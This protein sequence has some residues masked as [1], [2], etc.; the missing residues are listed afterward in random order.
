MSRARLYAVLASL[1]ILV[2]VML[3]YI[4][5]VVG[6][7][8][9]PRVT[10][11]VIEYYPITTTAIKYYPTPTTVIEY[12][13]IPK[14]S[15][16]VG[17][18]PRG[19][20]SV[21]GDY[22]QLHSLLDRAASRYM[23]ESELGGWFER[24]PLLAVTT[25]PAMIRPVGAVTPS[26]P[27][28]QEANVRVSWTNVQVEGVDELDIVKTNGRIIA[29]V[30]NTFNDSSI[31]IVD[32]GSKSVASRIVLTGGEVAKGLF[33]LGDRLVVVSES[34]GRKGVLTFINTGT[35]VFAVYDGNVT[36]RVFDVS[37]PSKPTLLSLTRVSGSLVD[38][39]M[40]EGV[41]YLVANQ[42]SITQEGLPLIPLVDMRPVDPSRLIVLSEDARRYI[43]I[44]ALNITSLE[45]NVVTLAGGPST[46]IYMSPHRLYIAVDIK[47]GVVEAYTIALRILASVI[48]GDEGK[49]IVELVEAGVLKEALNKAI[50]VLSRKSP[51]ESSRIWG[52]FTSK[53]A[54]V[55][56]RDETL[57]Y[58]LEVKGLNIKP[59]GS[60]TVKGLLLDQ[61]AIEEYR[62]KYLILATTSTEYSVEGGR[63][64]YNYIPEYKPSGSGV[65][66]TIIECLRDGTWSQCHRRSEVLPIHDIPQTRLSMYFYVVT[67]GSTINSVYVVDLEGLKIIGSLSELA[68]DERVFA[69]RLVKN[70]LFLVTARVV[71]PLFAI[72]ISDPSNPKVL[73]YL[74][75]P[76]FSEYLH[77]LPNDKLLG[78]GVEG[79]DLKIS[80]FDVSDPV[81]LREI[82]KIIITSTMGATSDVLRDHHAITVDL[83]YSRAYIPVSTRYWLG[84]SPGWGVAV[85]SFKE[86][87][88]KVIT[89]LDHP[90]ASRI[91]YIGGELYTISQDSIVVYNVD[92][93]EKI[94]V[95]KLR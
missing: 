7:G 9:V 1:A 31:F 73:G 53:L 38:G 51:E 49:S 46:R 12:Y 42:P 41:V 89:I 47:P 14:T 22:G 68:P 32:V 45:Y 86:D 66:V 25:V 95:I 34:P 59:L 27:T 10:T 56:V 93:L 67:R 60:I 33:L 52:E 72:D 87:V 70:I 5:S 43:S 55:R 23:L 37:N 8:F 44:L 88:L 29:V 19:L 57:V 64:Y 80:L 17:A 81:N 71:D 15:T 58:V 74:K 92:T 30:S 79:V 78:I 61:F 16:E 11:T 21:V 40:Y 20:I 63:L 82:S 75:I 50:D 28:S 76:G 77:P 62:D 65:V 13:P 91:T 6:G 90:G 4:I 24:L 84:Q 54:S 35:W 3:P 26:T 36:V 2:G 83:E 69:A 48:G 18:P 85:V 94:T 39:R